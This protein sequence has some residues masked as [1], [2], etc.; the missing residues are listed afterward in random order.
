MFGLVVGHHLL[1][2]HLLLD[3]YNIKYYTLFR[4]C[5]IRG[6]EPI[7]FLVMILIFIHATL[8]DQI[9]SGVFWFF[10]IIGIVR[11]LLHIQFQIKESEKINI[12]KAIL[13]GVYDFAYFSFLGLLLFVT[14]VLY[15]MFW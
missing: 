7:V 6:V 11:A 5:P 2:H 10:N 4:R 14:V 1:R 12:P 9:V 13:I 8:T 15:I 3:S